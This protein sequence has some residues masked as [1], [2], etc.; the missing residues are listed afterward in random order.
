[1]TRWTSPACR[2]SHSRE[3]ITRG[4]KSNGK[5]RSVPSFSPYTVNVMPWS[6]SES[7]C[8][9]SRRSISPWVKLSRI[10]TRG[11]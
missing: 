7:F 11:R 8:R 4:T 1:M 3:G 6:I 2:R 10:D 9:R 5:I